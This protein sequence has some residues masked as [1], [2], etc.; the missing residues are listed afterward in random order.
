M[1]L[2]PVLDYIP[3][4][5]WAVFTVGS[6][7]LCYAGGFELGKNYYTPR[8][9]SC[10]PAVMVAAI[11]GL[12]GLVLIFSVLI[13]YSRFSEK[14]GIVLKEAHAIET[15][16]LRAAYLPEPAASKIRQWFRDYLRIRLQ[17]TRPLAGENLTHLT[18]RIGQT[19]TK[20]E[21][22]QEALW[23]EAIL[24]AQ[25]N[26]QSTMGAL[27]IQA[28]NEVFNLHAARLTTSVEARLPGVIWLGLYG[29]AWLALFAL[30][31]HAG[32]GGE[33]RRVLPILLTLALSSII[34]VGIALD[35][36]WE[37]FFRINQQPLITLL[38]RMD[39]A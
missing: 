33:Q 9:P 8:P 31:Y 38:Q 17:G 15:A 27:F 37:G 13:A 16:Y 7:W 26:S 25:Q 18:E 32:W 23:K 6:L 1:I 10:G 30:G 20:S 34:L 39:D 36:P 29:F 14:R 21:N 19:V 24:M 35:R 4:W 22:I 2:D 28:L 3:L 11:L 12:T 5:G